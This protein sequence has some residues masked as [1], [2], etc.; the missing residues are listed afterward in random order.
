MSAAANVCR[1]AFRVDASTQIGTG[2]FMRCLT[3]ADALC[4]R[5]ATVHFIVRFLPDYLEL[6][7]ADRS[8]TCTRIGSSE[9]PPASGGLEHAVWLGTTQEVDVVQSLT[10]L[11]DMPWDWLIVDHY[12]LDV[13][14]ERAMRLRVRK[15]AAIDDIADRIHDC[16]VLIDQNFHEDAT[17][18]YRELVPVHCRL[19]LGPGYAMLRSEFRE[20][21]RNMGARSANV[22]RVLIF[23]GGMDQENYTGRV[24]E[25]MRSLDLAGMVVDVVI[26]KQHPYL[27]QIQEVCLDDGWHCHV[28]TDR[29]GQL[30]SAADMAI[31]AG[32]VAVWERCCVGLP[33]FVIPTA[34]NQEEQV[35]NLASRGAVY[36]PALKNKS[37][38]EV[39]GHVRALLGNSCLLR[40]FSNAGTAL[41]DGDGVLR[42]ANRLMGSQITMRRASQDDS[43][44]IFTWRNALAIRSVSRNQDLISWQDHQNWFAAVL[45][46]EA[47]YLL[48][49]ELF[50]RP[51]GV[52]RFDV[53]N[54]VAEVS[55]YLTP[56]MQGQGW[57]EDLLMRAEAWLVHNV[58]SVRYLKAVVLGENERSKRLFTLTG[59][60]FEQ[61]QFIKEIS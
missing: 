3:L 8:M 58:R 60:S 50:G 31:G 11:G 36:A 17:A 43:H 1:I 42:L 33:S 13:T 39:S 45:S 27:R 25:A 12:A 34:Q 16:D 22:K 20:A 38:D 5:G 28:Q 21:R 61:A 53:L 24:L 40:A 30:M 51:L 32:G 37:A 7:L 4:Q 44:N 2:H 6:M 56:G 26:G 52:V 57:G 46:S 49:G 55:I 47:K 15:I 19:L 29:M 23:F 59:Y 35:F 18:R 9:D 54:V 48:L 10:A 41:V 14:W